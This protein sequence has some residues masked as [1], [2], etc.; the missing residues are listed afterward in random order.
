MKKFK[1]VI[2]WG[3]PLNTHTHSFIQA[4]F[5]KTFKH[6]G[7]DTYW[8]SDTDNVEG[9]DFTECLFIAA[10]DQEK[11]IPIEKSSTYI[12]HNVDSRRYMEAGC[13]LLFIQTICKDV[14]NHKEDVKIFN[15][16]TVLKYANDVN[17][18]HIPWATDL[19]PHE[20]DL[21]NATNVIKSPDKTLP[22]CA[23]IGT[24]GGGDSTYQ[25]H[26]EVDPFFYECQNNG[27]RINRIDPWSR[28]ITF[29]ENCSIIRNAYVAPALQGIWQIENEYIPCRIF[30]NISYGHFGITNNPLVNEIFDNE[31]VFSRNTAELFHKA[32]ELKNQPNAI[33]RIKFLM[34]EV[35]EKHTYINRVNTMLECLPE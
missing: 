5:Y 4:S 6:L 21:N 24:Y 19:L 35:K 9:I 27:I 10:S 18:L 15:R 25:N 32:V 34:N 7:Y 1:K 29:E 12:L 33:E 13:K 31:L 2:V 17:C 23:W 14:I 8:F 30:K 3:Y 20:I 28:P 11:N 22:Y 16:Y 26:T